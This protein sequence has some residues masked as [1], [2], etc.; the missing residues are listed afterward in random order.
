MTRTVGG[1][2]TRGG[3]LSLTRLLTGLV[4]VKVLALALGVE[5]VGVYAILLQLYLTGVA[6]V[7]MSLAVPIINLGRPRL[8][9]GQV[10]E[11]GGVAGTAL[12][13]VGVNAVLLLLLA[14]VFG[15]A[16]LVQLGVG[17][18][19]HG[20]VWPIA[21]AIVIGA[22]SGAF[23]EG[24]S[25]L[26]DRFDI[27]VR[28]GMIGA[29]ADMLLVAGAA[30]AF[31]LEGAVYALPIG[32]AVMFVAFELSIGR[33]PVAR[34]LLRSLST[35]VA[36]L[37]PLFAYS[38]MMFSTVALTNAGLTFLRSRV[39]VEAGATANGYLQVATS[40]SSYLLA[41]VMTGFWGHIHARAAA[42]GDTPN[43]RQELTKS[44]SLGLLISF[45]GCG[46]AAVLAPFIIPIFYSNEFAAA[47]G[48]VIA[49]L[50]GELCFQL[51][52]MLIAYQLTVSHRRIY[53]ALNLGYIASLVAIGLV[54]IP[55]FGGYGYVAAH[56]IASL[57]MLGA[58][59]WLGW[60]KRQV[61]ARFL[62]TAATMV[63][64][65]AAICAALIYGR[66]VGYSPAY[67]LPALLPFAISGLVVLK[68]LRSGLS[69][70]N[71]QRLL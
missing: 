26:C 3:L 25:Y 22:C 31:G 53:V 65:L 40:L 12:A 56:V 14:A 17:S 13:V 16:L 24:M 52:S 71:S 19:D 60:H 35:R 63:V 33:D 43:V 48:Q 57:T 37:P 68:R 30:A 39:L 7:S 11:A 38:A 4:R 18:A 34:G 54:L 8:V 69:T 45:T 66:Q 61:S 50:P 2:M 51:L 36:F 5:G 49:Y 64:T 44:L 58:S 23:W 46:A 62:A 20:F 6:T 32:S 47:S 28:V 27:Y 9:A 42:E 10:A 55:R 15:E 21:A 1:A 70:P 41:F 67:M 59:G 29:I